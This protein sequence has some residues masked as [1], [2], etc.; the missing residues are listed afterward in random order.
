VLRLVAVVVVA[1]AALGARP[2]PCGH[3]HRTPAPCHRPG[4]GAAISAAIPG[5]VR[6]HARTRRSSHGRAGAKHRP[7]RARAAACGAGT[8]PAPARPTSE[9]LA[10][11]AM[12]AVVGLLARRDLPRDPGLPR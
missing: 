7:W 6:A 5:A 3:D 8:T 4:S 12:A 1:P 11:A 9:H 2:R 10:L